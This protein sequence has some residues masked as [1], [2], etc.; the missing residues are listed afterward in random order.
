MTLPTPPNLNRYLLMRP[1]WSIRQIKAPDPLAPPEE[2][3]PETPMEEPKEGVEPLPIQEPDWDLYRQ[4]YASYLE[5]LALYQQQVMMLQQG[6]AL[7]PPPPEPMKPQ[8]AAGIPRYALLPPPPPPSGPLT[9]REGLLGWGDE[10]H[11]QQKVAAEAWRQHLQQPMAK[12]MESNHIFISTAGYIVAFGM[13]ATDVRTGSGVATLIYASSI[14]LSLMLGQAGVRKVWIYFMEVALF[15]VF[16]FLWAFTY[17][18]GPNST[19]SSREINLQT[20]Y[21]F[22]VNAVMAGVA[23]LSSLMQY[24]LTVQYI[25]S[26]V[27]YAAWRHPKIISVA[28]VTTWVWILAFTASCLLYIVSPLTLHSFTL[29]PHPSNSLSL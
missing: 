21:P 2:V 17:P 29:N 10:A 22:I 14:G 9:W 23:L 11:W 16:L 13:Q 7:P 4:Q 19:P 26:M 28:Q 3:T 1:P 25:R 20:F 24:P 15:V 27:P 5:Q 8:Q 18:D 12:F 6:Q